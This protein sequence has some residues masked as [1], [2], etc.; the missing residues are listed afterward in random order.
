MTTDGVPRSPRGQEP[1]ESWRSG[2]GSSD[3]TVPRDP[4]A[5]AGR[6][7]DPLEGERGGTRN[8]SRCRGGEEQALEGRNPRRPRR[9]GSQGPGAERTRHGN[10]ALEAIAPGV[11]PRGSPTAVE[12]GRTESAANVKRAWPPKGG[13]IVTRKC[14]EGKIPWTLRH[15]RVSV[16]T[17]VKGREGGTQTSDVARD[18][19]GIP[20]RTRAHRPDTCRREAKAQERSIVRR[21]AS[22]AG[23]CKVPAV[24]SEEER[25]LVVGVSG[26]RVGATPHG[27]EAQPRRQ[28]TRRTSNVEREGRNQYASYAA[29][30][31]TAG[32]RATS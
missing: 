23:R 10:K 20:G 31:S 5:Q 22:A 21:V 1:H 7:V 9:P 14:L 8:E 24:I 28:K 17:V 15:L 3:L 6:N 26:E 12:I 18:R 32:S 13:P 27:S 19:G 29:V 25:E 2:N 30:V 11:T 16:G 4:E